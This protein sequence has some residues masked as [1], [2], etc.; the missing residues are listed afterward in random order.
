MR[1]LIPLLY[2][3]FFYSLIF[4]YKRVNKQ[5]YFVDE[6]YSKLDLNINIIFAIISLA[7]LLYLIIFKLRDKLEHICFLTTV[8]GLIGLFTDNNIYSKLIFVL[9]LATFCI[10]ISKKIFDSVKK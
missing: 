6:I 3:V 1:L 8:S 7:I 4:F 2:T 9:G 5:K 10:V